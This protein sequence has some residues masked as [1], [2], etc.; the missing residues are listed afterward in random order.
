M[1]TAAANKRW[2]IIILAVALLLRL[3]TAVVLQNRLDAAGQSFLIP[4]DADGYWHLG[5]QIAQGKEYSIYH[6]PRRVLRMPGFPAF[7]AGCILV[8]GG[9]L[10]PARIALSIV[11]TVACGLVYRLG[12]ELVDPRTGLVA[13]GL[14]A[15]SPAIVGFTPVILSETLFAAFMLG[16]LI[17]MAVLLR[18]HRDARGESARLPRAVWIRA[19]VTGLLIGLACYV[20]PSWLLAA[21]LFGM[22]LCL[23][24]RFRAAAIGHAVLILMVTLATLAPWGVRNSRVTG[25][26]VLT[27]LWVGPSL[28]DGLNPQATGDS[29]MT[30]F[31]RDNLLSEMSEYDVD[32][33]YRAAA[34]DF[35]RDN[36][37]RTMELAGVKLE[38]FWNPCPNAAQFQRWQACLLLGGF[39][40]PAVVL[41]LAGGW[42]LRRRP[43]VLL[44]TI[45][46]IVYFSAIH[47]VFV[48]SLRYRLPAEYP[49]LIATAVGLLAAWARLRPRPDS[50]ANG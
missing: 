22:A 32:R 8:A 36:P 37:G 7:L 18:R 2:L 33:H 25:H 4:G 39:F 15:V 11:G 50:S 28:Y 40:L 13:C 6:P 23:L 45:G 3:G 41:A 9:N 42:K 14:S 10:F 31:D 26:F 48:S 34:W 19:A 49:L 5:R 1:L 24:S 46:P 17:A 43:E 21:P 35:V 29:D 47:M 30:F 38:R 12:V 20:R 27:T 44:L 16:S